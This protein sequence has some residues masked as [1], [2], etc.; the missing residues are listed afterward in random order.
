VKLG[1]TRCPRCGGRMLLK[2][3]VHAE[4]EVKEVYQCAKCFYTVEKVVKFG[5]ERRYPRPY[6]HIPDSFRPHYVYL[7]YVP[8]H[9]RGVKGGEG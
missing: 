4:D 1:E 6:L 2:R 7:G 3:I 8:V 5:G 9:I